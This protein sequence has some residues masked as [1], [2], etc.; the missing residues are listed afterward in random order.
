MLVT[1]VTKTCSLQGPAQDFKRQLIDV[2]T[3][4]EPPVPTA[5][6]A[7][8]CSNMNPVFRT[9]PKVNFRAGGSPYSQAALGVYFASNRQYPVSKVALAS[10]TVA[11]SRPIS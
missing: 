8:P 3:F 5:C 1:V 4:L 7:Q 11:G 2:D 10:S 6:Y 9:T